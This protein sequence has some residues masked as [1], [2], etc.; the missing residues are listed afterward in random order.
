MVK[1][2]PVS[3]ATPWR[4]G[5]LQLLLR[6]CRWDCGQDAIPA[7]GNRAEGLYVDSATG[8]VDLC[9]CVKGQGDRKTSE[10]V[11]VSKTC[12]VRER[13]D[14][15]SQTELVSLRVGAPA[16]DPASWRLDPALKNRF[17]EDASEPSTL[18]TNSEKSWFLCVLEMSGFAG[19]VFLVWTHV[20]VATVSKDQ[21]PRGW[22]ARNAL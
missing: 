2:L 19:A 8:S 12:T 5:C 15:P 17:P 20:V 4:G 14:V 9:G 13:S 22:Y 18:P 11:S 7:R 16:R 1:I 6:A 21:D 3:G 10:C